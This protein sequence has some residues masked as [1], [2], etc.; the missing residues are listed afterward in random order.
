VTYKNNNTVVSVGDPEVRRDTLRGT[1]EGARVKIPLADIQTVQAKVH[2]GTK[3]ALL[4]GALGVAAVSGLYVAFISQAGSGSSGTEVVPDVV[5]I[6]LP[7]R[8]T[9]LL[10]PELFLTAAVTLITKY[11]GP[12]ATCF[13]RSTELVVEP[14]SMSMVPF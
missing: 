13:C 3:T 11:V 9:R 2:D 12:N 7:L 1:L 8:S 4:L 5:E 6:V 10:M 14:H